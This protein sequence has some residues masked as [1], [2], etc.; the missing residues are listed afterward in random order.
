MLVGADA[1]ARWDAVSHPHLLSA[2]DV[3]T[4]WQRL[5]QRCAATHPLEEAVPPSPLDI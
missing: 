5:P 1:T 2:A 3:D 4:A